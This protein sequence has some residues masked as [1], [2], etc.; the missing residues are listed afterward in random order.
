MSSEGKKEAKFEPYLSGVSGL[1]CAPDVDSGKGD[2]VPVHVFTKVFLLTSER[3][4]RCDGHETGQETP[5][6]QRPYGPCSIDVAPQ[7]P[8]LS[9]E[10][11]PPIVPVV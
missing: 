5:D 4:K 7:I 9:K 3:E 6:G 2:D 10:A 11:G 1:E 8:S